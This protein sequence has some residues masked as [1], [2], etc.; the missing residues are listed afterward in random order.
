L[1]HD[2][3]FDCLANQEEN[4]ARG[5]TFNTRTQT[6]IVMTDSVPPHIV[7]LSTH[8]GG[9][10]NKLGRVIPDSDIPLPLIPGHRNNGDTGEPLLL[11]LSILLLLFLSNL[12]SF[13]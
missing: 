6:V 10:N 1:S 2:Y 9:E 7:E 13:V 11:L 4:F 8:F 3:D 12:L 5:A